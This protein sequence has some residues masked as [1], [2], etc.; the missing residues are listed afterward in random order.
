MTES[1][2]RW[3]KGTV[4]SCENGHPMFRAVSDV[5]KSRTPR[6]NQLESVRSDLANPLNHTKVARCP[7]CGAPCIKF[8]RGGGFVNAQIPE[9]QVDFDD[10]PITGEPRG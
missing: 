1:D 2:I 4:F 8:G 3:P 9:I 5:D 10:A 6:G 7:E